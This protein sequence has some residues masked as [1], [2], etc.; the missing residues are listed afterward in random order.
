MT[1]LTFTY[2]DKPRTALFIEMDTRPNTDNLFCLT[3]D[4]MRTFKRTKMHNVKDETAII[5]CL[6]GD[7]NV[8]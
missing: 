3:Q 2:D 7:E 5:A 6:I 8:A 1:W 4:G